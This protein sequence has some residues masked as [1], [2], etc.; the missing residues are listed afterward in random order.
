MAKGG[1]TKG[2]IWKCPFQPEKPLKKPE[3]TLIFEVK[4][5]PPRNPFIDVYRGPQGVL[6]SFGPKCQKKAEWQNSVFSTCHGASLTQRVTFNTTKYFQMWESDLN[7]VTWCQ[8]DPQWVVRWPQSQ[9]KIID[10]WLMQ[11][12]IDDALTIL[13][14]SRE[15]QRILSDS[16]AKCAKTPATCLWR[17]RWEPWSCKVMLKDSICNR[18]WTNIKDQLTFSQ[19]VNS[20][21]HCFCDYPQGNNSSGLNVAIPLWVLWSSVSKMQGRQERERVGTDA[22]CLNGQPGR[23][24]GKHKAWS[25]G[26]RTEKQMF[27]SIVCSHGVQ[28]RFCHGLL[29]QSSRH[30]LMCK[31]WFVWVLLISMSVFPLHAFSH[32][33]DG[34]ERAEWFTNFVSQRLTQL[35]Q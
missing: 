11:G 18:K 16:P 32:Y 1:G 12:D 27:L 25:L 29:K 17:L 9:K 10:E 21:H 30:A 2:G 7:A 6:G 13:Q 5:D 14:V 4:C 15:I 24:N 31:V 8:N 26:L 3:N 22:S 20:I 23:S 19:L 34:Y 28:G 35:N 33:S